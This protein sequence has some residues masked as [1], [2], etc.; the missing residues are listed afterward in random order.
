M[1]SKKPETSLTLGISIGSI[2][3][4]VILILAA[5]YAWTKRKKKRFA[6]QRFLVAQFS[7]LVV[8]QDQPSGVDCSVSCFS[9]KKV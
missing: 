9:L 6:W 4:S 5:C 3:L 7:S 8:F 2:S 1:P